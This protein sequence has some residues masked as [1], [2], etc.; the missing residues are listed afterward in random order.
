M[1]ERILSG[2]PASP[3]LAVGPAVVLDR[4]QAATA[5]VAPGLRAAEARR[6]AAALGAAAAQ[7]E[8]LADG[9]GS[10]EAE[11]VRTGALMALDPALAADVEALTGSGLDARAALTAAADKH[12]QALAAIPDETLAARADDVRSLGR[13]AVRVLDGAGLER[14]AGMIVARTLGPAD[15]AELHATADGFALADGGP[16]AHA[17]IVARALGLP[18]VTGL[19]EEVLG[20]RA[21]EPLVIDGEAG[22][23]TLSPAPQRAAAAH[24]AATR[25]RA[26]RA[27]AAAARDLPAVTRDGQRVLVLANAASATEVPLALEAGAEG[28][29][30]LRTELT[31]LEAS[32][33]PDEDQHARAL[34]PVLGQLGGLPVTVRVLDFGGDK[35][36][37][38]LAGD[39]RR[40]I[41]LLLAHPDALAAQLRAIVRAG[42]EVALRV[43]L[44]L[45]ED[46]REVDA[47]RAL[48]PAGTQVGAMIETPRAAETA[49]A[50]AAASDFLSIGTNDLTASTLGLDRFAAERGACHD[51]RVLDRI[52]HTVRAARVAGVPLEVCGEA[53]SHPVMLP[54][55]VGL[56][57]REVSVGA[58][59]VGTVRAWVRELDAAACC[60][61]VSA[62]LQAAD[63]GAVESLVEPVA[64]RLRSVERDDAAAQSLERD[65]GVVAVGP[66]P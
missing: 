32:R 52:R 61:L 7:L 9:L 51:P 50:L 40:G 41:S 66:Q 16:T 28:V 4:A 59:R 44:P 56:G 2:L 31:F 25:R 62:A 35:L 8:A 29:G 5:T 19:G 18:M 20:A 30:L 21:G 36:P 53:A 10:E 22:T 3:G 54:L 39:E 11:I 57:V 55:L 14:P 45:V 1:A 38:F 63:A 43:M 60:T 49:E 13:R 23:L 58:A 42:S 12:A 64:E 34:S 17:A 26:T 24:Q 65:G 33:W 46:P 37:P 27:R 47:V 6:A 15:V 48:L